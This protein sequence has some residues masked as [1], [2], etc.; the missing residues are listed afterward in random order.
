M[1]GYI[2]TDEDAWLYNKWKT[3][4]DLD[5]LLRTTLPPGPVDDEVNT[6]KALVPAIRVNELSNEAP[7]LLGEE[8]K[9]SDGATPAQDAL[10]LVP[11]TPSKVAEPLDAG[12][13]KEQ[14]IAIPVNVARKVT[15]HTAV[16]ETKP[17]FHGDW[18]SDKDIVAWL[19]DQS[20]HNEVGWRRRHILI[21]NGDDREGF[22]WFVCAMDCIVLVCPFKVHIWEPLL[23]TCLVRPRLKRLQSKGVS[24]HAWALGFQKDGW[25]CGYESLRLCDEVAGHEGSLEDVDVVLTH[26]PKGFIKEALRIINAD[27]SV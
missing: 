23:G 16:D 2:P 13:S 24:T 8:G 17:L 14:D 25:S 21:V 26:V 20:Y 6:S 1:R 18:L 12:T 27:P 22:H 10:V 3:E 5:S 11:I 19:I 4:V 7:S 9:L 15:R